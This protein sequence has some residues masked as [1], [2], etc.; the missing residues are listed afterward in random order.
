MPSAPH[1]FA[2]RHL[3]A[4]ALLLSCAATAAAPVIKSPNDP[5]EY[6]AFTLDNGLRVVVVSDP[7]AD[8]AA[9]SLDVHVG[10]ASDPPGREG[11]SH[12][13][14]HMLFLGTGKYPGAGE[15]QQF[16]SSHG[17]SHNAYT[18]FEDTNYFFDVEAGHLEAA[19]DRFAQFFVAPLFTER[20]VQRER[21]AVDSEYQSKLK[22][23]GWRVMHA[24][25]SEANPSHPYARYFGGNAETLADRE[26][27]DIR[28]ELI[29]FWERHYSADRMALSVL[30]R[31]PTGVLR[32][33][34]E[35]RFA[36]VR[37][38]SPPTPVTDQPLFEPGR[39]PL[40]VD[41]EPVLEQR[42]L[43]LLFPIPSLEAHT[44]TLPT[45]YLANLVGHEG[46]GSLLSLFKRRGWAEGL[47]AG[48]ALA[49]ADSATFQVGI[50]LTESGLE[51]VDDIVR[52]VF[53]YLAL[54]R[55][56]GVQERI[57]R[58][59]QRLAEIGFEFASPPAPT[60]LVRFIAANLHHYPAEEVLHGPTTFARFDPDLIR[61]FLARLVPDNLLLVVTA[62]G[63]E[64]DR[65]TRFFD[66]AYRAR[67]ITDSRLAAWRDP[68]GESQLAIPGPNEF[69][70]DDL[71]VKPL[72]ALHDV[73]QRIVATPLLELWFRQDE[74][75][76]LPRADFYF[77]VRSPHA[78]GD[79]RESVLTDLYVSMVKDN[80]NEYSYPASLAGLDYSLYRHSRGFSVRMSGY[81]DKQPVLLARLADTLRT[82]DLD[83]QRFQGAREELLRALRNASRDTPY[84]RAMDEL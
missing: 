33:W 9:A 5:R 61:D 13:L 59:N 10:S 26:G 83:E 75:W 16:I 70:P 3:L 78:N 30:G 80:L 53:A 1:R 66:A 47:H 31:E 43:T 14:E 54:V 60:S 45:G 41:V 6:E 74:R 23:D 77:S 17:G 18:A 62:P 48:A 28:A 4:C 34:V 65:R 71:A 68:A 44:D 36:A 2:Y 21:N 46:E 37:T 52:E 40:Q 84:S 12:F 76:R 51:H 22:E 32:R 72:E 63:V 49:H 29:A 15:Y 56:Q 67:P 64:T 57:F 7:Q 42:T 24:W 50:T 27:S 82:P 11:L 58:E 39:L 73:P 35:E 81:E 69:V 55:E 20:Y 25:K 38:G 19:L 79:A 8:T